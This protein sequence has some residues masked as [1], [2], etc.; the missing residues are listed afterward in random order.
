MAKAINAGGLVAGLPH[1]GIVWP[2]IGKGSVLDLV[3]QP[4]PLGGEALEGGGDCHNQSAHKAPALILENLEHCR[5]TTAI[6]IRE[7]IV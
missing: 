7:Q 3:H 2:F 5:I 4:T 1:L 6:G